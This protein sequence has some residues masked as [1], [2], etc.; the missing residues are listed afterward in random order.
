MAKGGRGGRRSKS[1]SKVTAK[2]H[3]PIRRIGKG[4]PCKNSIQKT[5]IISTNVAFTSQL[6]VLPPCE[7]VL[8]KCGN[9]RT[10]VRGFGGLFT[11]LLFENRLMVHFEKEFGVAA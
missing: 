8:V 10:Y 4:N 5:S 1:T 11:R 3:A 9:P 2:M 7:H 6:C